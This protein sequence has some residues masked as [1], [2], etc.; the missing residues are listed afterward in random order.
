M[1]LSLGRRAD[2]MVR[3]VLDL[4]VHAGEGRRKSGEIAADMQIPATYL[5][6]L[7]AELVRAG[8]V[9]ST[10]GRRGGY[11]LA[12]EPEGLSLL[13]V[14][15]LADGE[16]ITTVCVLRGGPCRW[17]DAC[18]VHPPLARAQE[19]LRSSLAETTFAEVADIDR[20]LRSQT[21]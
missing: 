6:Q 2:Y 3:A 9:T 7:L 18:A 17:D 1:E 14:I 19:R 4:A 11:E 8:V 15:E 10:A 5:P 13:E 12:R 21:V 20:G 16:L